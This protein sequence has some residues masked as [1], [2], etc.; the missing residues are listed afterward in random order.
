MSCSY[1]VEI[2]LKNYFSTLATVNFKPKQSLKNMLNISH[3]QY[4]ES[5]LNKHVLLRQED[6]HSCL[7]GKHRFL[8]G[9]HSSSASCMQ[10]KHQFTLS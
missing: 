8:E 10:N 4:R 9:K 3:T 5:Q 2:I 6:K 7:E 1:V